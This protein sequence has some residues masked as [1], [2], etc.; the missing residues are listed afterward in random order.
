MLNELHDLAKSLSAVNVVV[1]S[2]HQHF[3]P[4]PK[5]SATYLLLID[6]APS[7]SDLEVIGD[8]ER[9]GAIR[10]WE[11]AAG[12][13]FPAFN[14]WPLFEPCSEERKKAATA[15][16]KELLSNKPPN[17]AD[18][19][20]RL[21]ELIQ[22]SKSLW[23][24]KELARITKCIAVIGNELVATLGA[25]PKEFV[26][27]SELITRT[28]YF[29]AASLHSR[30]TEIL[31]AKLID[32]PANAGDWFDTLFF[33]SG[34]D[35]KRCQL[36]A[37]LAD[38]S[39]FEY[40]ATHP[41][42]QSWMNS[43]F[44]QKIHAV[45]EPGTVPA[46]AAFDAFALPAD[47]VKDSFPA[48]KL[49]VLSSVILRSMSD[50]SPC[51][52]RYGVAGALSC[53]VGQVSRQSM[54]NALEW[55]GHPDRQ[56]KTWSDVSSLVSGKALLFAYPSQLP[57]TDPELAG[58][59][60]GFAEAGDPDGTT[61]AA[62]AA[63]V[64]ESLS[65]LSQAGSST[66]IRVFVLAHPDKARTKLL[67][68]G[69]YTVDRIVHSARD[70]HE[71]CGNIPH[72]MIRQFGA[73]KGD[74]A[75]W[76]HAATPYPGQLVQCLN[77]VWERSGTHATQIHSFGIGDGLAL[78]LDRGPVL[79]ATAKRA[80]RSLV[81]NSLSL[82]LALGQAQH[83]GR[84]HPMGKKEAIQPLILP[85]VFGLL[86]AKLGH[87]KG[88]YMTGPPFLV[89][90]LLSLA[91]QLH[92]QYCLGVRKGQIPPQLAGNALMTTAM[93]SPQKAVVL[94]WQRIKPYYAWAQTVQGGDEVR[95][96]K[97]FLGQLGKVSSELKDTELPTRCS[98]PEKAELLLGY[99]A[100][101][102]KD[103]HASSPSTI[104]SESASV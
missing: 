56:N 5:G 103:N 95:L 15:L 100:R 25:P 13:S 32:Q 76:A 19:H 68:S 97:Y 40:P 52:R 74:K 69:R 90:R 92:V 79:Q 39:A 53:Q 6:A 46:T 93:D 22:I 23:T 26:A 1:E 75:I 20:S 42:V 64:T 77:T 35:P 99:L 36:V 14:V 98:D 11:V 63:R 59:I 82:I 67:H 88:E 96:A 21:V 71:G 10:K 57:A 45:A 102:E 58:L 41:R 50:E 30:L 55:I 24:E 72:L 101:A 80:I 66:Q 31:S 73:T 94:L 48:V 4:C 34:K 12:F 83:Q 85:C 70:W 89:G 28:S 78:L 84:A 81:S 61:F 3:K 16:R 7:V 54:K 44:A 104:E 33:H 2:W 27:I 29:N 18:I 49:P 38:R 91:D 87:V 8:R 17:P 37:E 65:K 62:C 86:L 51:Q 9:V 43:R 60:V 47:G